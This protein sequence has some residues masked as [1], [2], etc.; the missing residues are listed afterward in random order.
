MVHPNNTLSHAS[1]ASRP[2][3][4]IK[5]TRDYSVAT[6]AGERMVTFSSSGMHLHANPRDVTTPSIQTLPRHS[7]VMG[8][9]KH[10]EAKPKV[11]VLEVRKLLG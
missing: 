3:W 1:S 5:G 7:K 4:G 6:A 10:T 2:P 9:P 11:G 8:I